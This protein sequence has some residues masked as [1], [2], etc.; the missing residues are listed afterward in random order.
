MRI[1]RG[2]VAGWLVLLVYCIALPCAGVRLTILCLF[3]CVRVY[4]LPTHS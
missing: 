2:R 3:C 1:T 4:V